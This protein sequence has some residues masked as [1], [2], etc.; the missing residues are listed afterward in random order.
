MNN[1]RRPLATFAVLGGII[2]VLLII[3]SGR[4]TAIGDFS[5]AITKPFAGFIHRVADVFQRDPQQ[6]TT[7]EEIDTLR[8][9]NARLSSENARLLTLEDENKRLREYLVFAQTQKSS[10]QM[11]EIIARGVAGDSW[12][13]RET[14]TLNQGSDQGIAVGM[15]IVSSEGVL[16]GK[17][18]AVKNNISEVCFMYSSDCR[19]AVTVAGQGA[20]LG[21]AHGDL[22][23]SVII[24]LIPQTRTVNEN[25]V[26][27]SSGLEAG[28]PPGLL[29]GS[30]SRVIK[31]G[32]ELWQ[33]AIVE[34]ATDVDT[35]RFVA[36]VKQ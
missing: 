2:I 19:I 15:P 28:M 25:D 22:G 13:N 24:E 23:L 29:V 31:E 30:V 14:A 17:I 6:A 21:M 5:R 35:L 8:S 10:L 12:Q 4:F 27:V 20:T 26:I 9:E 3:A 32:N 16:V 18:T 34:P 11:A 36:I 1:N 33:Q 7:Q